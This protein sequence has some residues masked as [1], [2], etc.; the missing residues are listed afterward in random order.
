ME[1]Q[2]SK[3]YSEFGELP[4]I[5]LFSGCGGMVLGFHKVGFKT[6]M[7]SEYDRKIVPTYRHNF[8]DVA[9]ADC[10]INN[11]PD[12]IF[13]ENTIG[14]IGGPPCQSWSIGGSKR[15]IEDPRG[16]LFYEYI[17]VLKAVKP[18][19]FVAEN[20]MGMLT[21]RHKESVHAILEEFKNIGYDVHV[22]LL[23]ASQYDCPQDRKRVFYVGFLKE[24]EVN[25]KFPTPSNIKRTYQ[26][27]IADLEGY[28]IPARTHN[29]TNGKSCRIPNHE[30]F[31]GGFSPM[32]M[33]R[34]RVR[35]WDQEGFTVQ[36]SGRQCQLHPSS[37][38]M[39]FISRDK[40]EFDKN[41]E[42]EYRRLTVRECARLQTFPDD[43]LFVYDDVNVGY[44]MIGNAVPVNLAEHI[45]ESVLKA[46]DNSPIARDMVYSRFHLSDDINS[47]K[48]TI[49][50]TLLD[51]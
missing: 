50:Q 49:E 22:G 48:Q 34:Q 25:Y 3:L 38:K 28:E 36:A 37:P 32:F 18:L 44:K 45:A 41:R 11:V 16:K 7:A 31:I 51:F 47:L 14:V 29:K 20:V 15:G 2:T 12:F 13:P 42:N 10:D 39:I 24:L 4:I 5:S 26:T 21:E 17:R 23:N 33:S 19:F 40:F 46:L 35:D 8:P 30:Y 9:M 6:I 43:F 1:Q 27:D